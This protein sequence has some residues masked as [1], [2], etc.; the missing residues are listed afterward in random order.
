MSDNLKLKGTGR[1]ILTYPDGHKE[2]HEKHNLITTVGY[3]TLIGSLIKSTS[4]P[5]PLSHV[6]IGTGTT[7]SA[8]SQTTLVNETNRGAG[9][10]TWSSGS[11][12]FTI[13]CAFARGTVSG[14][15]SE[16]GVFNAST[17][18]SMFDRC[19]FTNPIPVTSEIQ[20]TQEFEFEVM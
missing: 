11:K 1:A 14:N 4:R 16:G 18:G 3:D 2:V 10:W 6:A 20:Y 19:V 15:I 9:T 17:G 5:N 7:A 12:T 13:S 8:V